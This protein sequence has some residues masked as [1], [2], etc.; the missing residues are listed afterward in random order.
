MN[1]VHQTPPPQLMTRGQAA[2][3]LQV[4]TRTFDRLR[5]ENPLPFVRLRK[6]KMYRRRDLEMLINE[7]RTLEQFA[8]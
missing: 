3:F 5:S 4:S 6:R 7:S 2:A 8:E 1:K